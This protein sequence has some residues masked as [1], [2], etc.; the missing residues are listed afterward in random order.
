MRTYFSKER[1]DEYLLK[2]ALSPLPDMAERFFKIQLGMKALLK[3]WKRLLQLALN[4]K[5]IHDIA[6]SHSGN[7][8]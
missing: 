4:L 2:A 6:S 5:D 3:D 1:G 7:Q 8:C